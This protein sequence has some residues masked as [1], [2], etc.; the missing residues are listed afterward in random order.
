MES[1]I[2]DSGGESSRKPDKADMAPHFLCQIKVLGSISLETCLPKR[3]LGTHPNLC[4]YLCGTGGANGECEQGFCRGNMPK[5]RQGRRAYP[6][7]SLAHVTTFVNCCA[8]QEGANGECEQ[9]FCMGIGPK[10]NQG[11]HGATLLVPNQSIRKYWCR[12]DS[13]LARRMSRSGRENS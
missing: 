5:A 4:Q 7:V 13:F 11:R 3:L 12:G 8:K 6:D 10:T 1:A 9:G 2:R